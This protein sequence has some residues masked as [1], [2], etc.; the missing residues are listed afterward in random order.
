M[1]SLRHHRNL[2]LK[3]LPISVPLPSMPMKGQTDQLAPSISMG[4]TIAQLSTRL[5]CANAA[6]DCTV[7]VNGGRDQFART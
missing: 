6:V 2:P 1:D 3:L 5:R 4:L 7:I